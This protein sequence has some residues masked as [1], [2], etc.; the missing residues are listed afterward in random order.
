MARMNLKTGINRPVQSQAVNWAT[1]AGRRSQRPE[2]GRSRIPSSSCPPF[3]VAEVEFLVI[4]SVPLH[5]GS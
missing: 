3:V 4:L 1:A 2:G 5:Y